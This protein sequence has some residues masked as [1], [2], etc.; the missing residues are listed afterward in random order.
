LTVIIE[1]HISLQS[2]VIR[3]SI[4]QRKFRGKNNNSKTLLKPK[5][6]IKEQQLQHNCKKYKDF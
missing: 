4:E 1:F 6:T 3:N 2:Q 5:R